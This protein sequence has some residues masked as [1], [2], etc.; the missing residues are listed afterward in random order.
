MKNRFNK[1]NVT[2]NV[3]PA[4]KALM[5]VYSVNKVLIEW[6]LLITVIVCQDIMIIMVN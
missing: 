3:L 6:I 5:N 1:F 4:V 2:E